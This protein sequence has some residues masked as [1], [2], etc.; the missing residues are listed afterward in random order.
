MLRK[1]CANFH[2]FSAEKNQ[3]YIQTADIS[4]MKW[5]L[6]GCLLRK[7]DLKKKNNSI[8]HLWPTPWRIL[9]T[10]VTNHTFSKC[11]RVWEKHH[12]HVS[13]LLWIRTFT[14]EI[15]NV[16]QELP[17]RVFGFKPQPP[18]DP[19]K[20]PPVRTALPVENHHFVKYKFYKTINSFYIIG[21]RL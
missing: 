14:N 1:M 13:I 15:S 10:S 6:E 17:Y 8:L 18:C 3:K 19:Q 12:T 11:P 9:S 16:V 2:P 4:E 5:F 20:H 21:S 7:I